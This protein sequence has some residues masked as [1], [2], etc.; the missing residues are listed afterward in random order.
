[1]PKKCPYCGSP[2]IHKEG[3]VAVRCLNRNCYQQRIRRIAFFASKDA[4]DIGHLG[5]KVVEQL[6][7][8]GLVC[9]VSDL[10]RLTEAELA[11]LEGFKEKSI[12]NLLKSIDASRHVSLPRF[13]LSLGIKYI[14]EGTADLLA[15]HAGDIKKLSKMSREELLEIEGIGEKIADSVV[16]YFS[17]PE[18]VE[19][20]H[21]LLAFKVKPEAV[22]AVTRKTHPFY[23]KTFV[24]TGALAEYTRSEASRLIKE[25]GGKV[26][27]S[28]S[29][30]TDYVLAGEDPGSKLDK[31]EEL[32]VKVISE[33]HFKKMLD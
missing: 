1:M 31:A 2:V 15:M 4:M 10:Y 22:K 17:D 27:S 16:Q 25:R 29:K 13:I 20:I 3:E 7:E 5:Q 9:T 6:V 32:G 24:L 28:V 23:G 19:E 14:G 18:N 12:D 30:Q 21:A 8:R 26:S 11:T 33:A